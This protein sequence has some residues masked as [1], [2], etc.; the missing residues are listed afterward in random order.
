MSGASPSPAEDR[1]APYREGLAAGEL[2]YQHCPVCASNWLPA[3]AACPT[4]LSPAPEWWRSA[5]RGRIVSWVVYHVAYHDSF[6]DRLPY[7]VTLVELDEGPRL[8]T[9]IVDGRAGAALAIGRRVE[10]AVER[11]GEVVLARFR[12]AADGAT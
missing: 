1:S 5:G 12:L 2:R 9:N 4:C 10:L 6:K 3:R 8:L 11:E 7:D